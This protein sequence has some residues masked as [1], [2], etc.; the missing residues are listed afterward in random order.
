ME[1][2]WQG[3]AV[4]VQVREKQL[5]G[6]G[7]CIHQ[8]KEEGFD[9]TCRTS[10]VQTS[11]Q[12]HAA[13]QPHPHVEDCA[14][15][16][17]ARRGEPVCAPL[18]PGHQKRFQPASPRGMM[19]GTTRRRRYQLTGSTPKAIIVP[20][21]KRGAPLCVITGLLMCSAW[22]WAQWAAQQPA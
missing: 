5:F 17:V 2:H 10:S 4:L 22:G 11:G 6:S 8:H 7:Q 16:C 14:C 18:C 1:G 15:S 21:C 13:W 19:S 9:Q 12:A 3:H 20:N